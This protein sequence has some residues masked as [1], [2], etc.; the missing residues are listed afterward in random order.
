MT[1]HTSLQPRL[2]A[3]GARSTTQAHI[4]Y[5]V[6]GQ[7]ASVSRFEPTLP[8]ALPLALLMAGCLVLAGGRAALRRFAVALPRAL[9]A[10]AGAVLL[11]RV[12]VYSAGTQSDV[13]AKVVLVFMSM[14]VFG[15]LVA[16]QRVRAHRL[17]VAAAAVVALGLALAAPLQRRLK[18]EALRELQTLETLAAETEAHAVAL[19]RWPTVEEWRARHSESLFVDGC[20]YSYQPPTA[21]AAASYGGVATAYAIEGSRAVPGDYPDL[22]STDGFGADG[23]FATGDDNSYWLAPRYYGQ[24]AWR[25]GRAPRDPRVVLPAAP[26]G[27]P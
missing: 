9:A 22:L 25:H 15:A 10:M 11:Y 2:L 17:A 12:A 21:N 23:L 14:A 16:V 19:G 5:T 13:P 24:P 6:I 26:G 20:A 8:S 27:K 18:P 4:G 1:R 7:T 3:S